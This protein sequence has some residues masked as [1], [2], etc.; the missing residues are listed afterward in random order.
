MI[1]HGKAGE[2]RYVVAGRVGAVHGSARQVWKGE[3]MNWKQKWDELDKVWSVP[4]ETPIP[5]GAE[6]SEETFD[7]ILQESEEEDDR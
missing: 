1:R 3:N 2:S 7:R 4:E 6:I 5:E